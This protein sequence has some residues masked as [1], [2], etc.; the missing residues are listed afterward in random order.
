[1]D[2]VVHRLLR[3]LPDTKK[4]R[5]DIAYERGR[6]QA[7]SALLFGGMA[8]GL[9]SGALGMFL[10]DPVNGSARRA[11]LAQRV[12]AR[13]D[14][15]RQ[16]LQ[17]RSQDLRNRVVGTATELG[18]PGTPPS[19]AERR[20][21]AAALA[22]SPSRP[23]LRTAPRSAAASTPAAIAPAAPA[24]PRDDTTDR[25]PVAAGSTER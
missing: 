14:D 15:L 12:R 13:F 4:D 6:A 17:G 5:Y 16:T 18:L 7:R 22:S 11:E 23:G 2:D 25:V 24:A 21:A 8:I 1:M 9:V 19:N 10:L 3:E 20:E